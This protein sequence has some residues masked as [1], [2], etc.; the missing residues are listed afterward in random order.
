MNVLVLLSICG[1][2]SGRVV[3]GLNRVQYNMERGG[4]RVAL[5]SWWHKQNG[6][7]LLS[8][9]LFYLACSSVITGPQGLSTAAATSSGTGRGRECNVELNLLWMADMSMACEACVAGGMGMEEPMG[10]GRA[11]LRTKQRDAEREQPRV[12]VECARSSSG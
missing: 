3:A 5:C 1:C 8:T 2:V 9:A 10:A 4:A 6:S 7:P 11:A 12:K